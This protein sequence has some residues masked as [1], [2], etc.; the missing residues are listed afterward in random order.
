MATV[1]LLV[2]LRVGLG[3]HF[4]YEGVWKIKHA[5]EFTA[6]PFLTQAKGPMAPLF[7][8]ML[9]DIDGRQRLQVELTFDDKATVGAI[10]SEIAKKYGEKYAKEFTERLFGR[11]A[12]RGAKI[13]LGKQEKVAER[14]EAFRQKFLAHFAPS[15]SA[16]D[17]A[18]QAHQKLDDASRKALDRF[19][20]DLQVYLGANQKRIEGYFGS[21]DRFQQDK[22]RGQGTKFQKERQW[23][24]M[25]QLRGEVAVW[26]GE[27]DAR[28]KAFREALYDLVD[29]KQLESRGRIA[30]SWN[31][32]AWS[33]V[34]QIN[35]AVT[36]AL[37]AIGVCLLLGL[38]TRPAALGGAGFMFFVVL[39][40]PAWPT[41][42]P[43][44]PAVVGH[45]LLIN[46]DF[47]EMLA[48]LTIATTAVGRWAGLDYFLGNLVV[49]PVL[50]KTLRKRE[51]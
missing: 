23:D 1:V 31:P 45:A 15:R 9:P 30:A 4:L 35:F 32:F 19:V 10:E 6:E 51:G 2:A 50:S 38:C 26:L 43:P 49:D 12:D 7:Y 36:W 34:E 20:Y 17:A 33:R 48:L 8:A 3:F 42:W 40:Q 16:D 22:E 5:D 41:I 46:K 28:E 21:L 25:Q 24:T 44:D 47:I 27:I 11:D 29:A 18:K 14:W 39:T 13:T 37:T